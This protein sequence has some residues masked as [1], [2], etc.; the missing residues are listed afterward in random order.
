[1]AGRLNVVLNAIYAAF[2]QGRDGLVHLGPSE[3]LTGEALRFARLV[4][5]LMLGGEIKP[6]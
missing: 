3:P 2:G 4:F 5:F 6:S 1:M